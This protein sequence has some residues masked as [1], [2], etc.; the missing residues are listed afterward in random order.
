MD[1]ASMATIL[2]QSK[3]QQQ[4]SLSVMKIAMDTTKQQ[5]FNLAEL[6]EV[7]TKL[8]EQSVNPHIGGNLDL[9]I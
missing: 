9:E 7:N 5:S 6:L 4:A 1:I 2:S 3:I 8:M